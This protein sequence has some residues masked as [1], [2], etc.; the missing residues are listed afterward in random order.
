[1]LTWEQQ[2]THGLWYCYCDTVIQLDKMINIHF[3]QNFTLNKKVE[4]HRILLF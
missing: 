3:P 4:N 1:M 2:E